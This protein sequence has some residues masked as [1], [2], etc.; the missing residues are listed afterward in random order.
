MNP[1]RTCLAAGALA[2]LVCSLAPAQGRL[3]TE[4]A[5]QATLREY[6]SML[7]VDDF[8]V[9]AEG[10]EVPTGEPSQDDLF[11][12]WLLSPAGRGIS[13]GRLAT[14]PEQFLLASIEGDEAVMRPAASPDG[15]AWLAGWDFPCNPY[16]GARALKLRAFVVC[17][18]D[19]VMLDALHERN[20]AE[21]A[22][23]A[24]SGDLIDRRSTENRSD[25]LGGTLIWLAQAYGVA[26]D[27]L[28]PAV[29]A[30][31]ETGLRKFFVRLETWGPYGAMTDMDLFAAVGMQYAARSIGDPDLAARAEAYARPL[32]TE[33]RFFH[34]AGYYVDVGCYDASYNGISLYFGNWAALMSG[35]DF[36]REATARA[37]RLRGHLVLPEPRGGAFGPSHFSSRTSAGTAHEQW[38]R[39]WRHAAAAMVADDAMYA[40]W[41]PTPDAARAAYAG[42]VKSL[43]GPI[44]EPGPRQK[45]EP[46]KERHW[47]SAI[48]YPHDFYRP[49][50]AARL[51]AAREAGSDNCTFPFRGD[52]TFVRRFEDAFVAARFEQY[53]VVIHTGP[54][55]GDNPS[56]K[57][58]YGF[59]GGAISA[60]WTPDCGSAL[61]GRRRG[62][63]GGTYDTYDG[64]RTWPTHAA[65][66]VTKSGGV[67]SS[68]RIADPRPEFKLSDASATVSVGGAIPKS[69]AAHGDVLTAD[70]TY[71][72]RF[73]VYEGGVT[74]TTE[75]AAAPPADEVAELYETFPVFLGDKGQQR[76]LP[77][78]GIV[79]RRDGRWERATADSVDGVDAVRVDR[80]DGSVIVEFTEAQRVRL[81]PEIWTDGYQSSVACRNVMVELFDASRAGKAFTK[82]RLTYTVRPLAG[83]VSEEGVVQP[84]AVI[85][86]FEDVAA[87]AAALAELDEH[88]VRYADRPVARLRFALSGDRL[89]LH[90]RVRDD[91]VR[92]GGK[93]WD[94]S[95]V[96]AFGAV[97]GKA[98]VGQVF[99]VPAAGEAPA[100]AFRVQKKEAGTV[101]ADD[102]LVVSDVSKDGYELRALI[103]LKHL[104]LDAAVDEVLMEIQVS[105]HMRGDGEGAEAVLRHN[106]LFGSDR[107]YE[108]KRSYGLFRPV[109]REPSTEP[110]TE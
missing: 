36:A 88:I 30:A 5:Y 70:I 62:I 58:P 39:M 91:L 48:P 85:A 65:T 2:V 93:Q 96:E 76:L 102:V 15:I 107:A 99:L 31:Y 3:P 8:A 55:S 9:V 42:L 109:R 27:A 17:A 6:L 7:T 81:S 45:A 100:A 16:H 11:R 94:G 33:R 108:D 25:Y 66:G 35:W 10:V 40:I 74:V 67:F 104:R 86:P 72:R 84:L 87:V 43:S 64:W 22:A 69:N 97:P 1:I 80:F 90:A 50:F 68:A 60:F 20:A 13:L 23:V 49:G 47:S 82:A 89:A 38:N 75:L 24:D 52:G 61:L 98:G 73:D 83:R 71:S 41:P 101:P 95:C 106:T 26:K 34:P 59:G 103:P 29:A 53:G 44:P 51:Q 77:V 12:A 21:A 57:R 46:W 78:R 92:R 18:V 110:G 32:F 56:R 79:F 37:H 4:H 19:A 54:V 105:G 63:Q 28:P 14:P